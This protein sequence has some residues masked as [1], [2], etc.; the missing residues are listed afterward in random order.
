[1][2]GGV[3]PRVQSHIISIVRVYNT[4]S[5]SVSLYL[6]VFQEAHHTPA[7]PFGKQ[8]THHG[9][10]ANDFAVFLQRFDQLHVARPAEHKGLDRDI[11][12]T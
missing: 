10:V 1:M 11:C 2:P 7:S 5:L 6:V 9:V 4:R 3:S 8:T 12:D